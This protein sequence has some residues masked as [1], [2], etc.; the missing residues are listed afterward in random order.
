MHAPYNTLI[1][2]Y[3]GAGTLPPNTLKVVAP[4]RLVREDC[5]LVD[6]PPLLGHTHYIT[7]D[8]PF[9]IAGTV[10]SAPSLVSWDYSTA[11]VIEEPFGSGVRWLVKQV[12]M[13]TPRGLGAV[14]YYRVLVVPFPGPGP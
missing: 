11:D 14:P 4:A 7:T 5:V 6:S 1:G 10:T 8:T 12:W 9:V 3:T 2:V 13:V